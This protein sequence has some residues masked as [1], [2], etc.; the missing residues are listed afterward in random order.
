MC[1]E[2]NNLET[3]D[4]L[5]G[6]LSKKKIFKKENKVTKERNLVNEW[7]SKDIKNIRVEDFITN[8]SIETPN[9]VNFSK[10]KIL[11]HF[12][13]EKMLK[14]IKNQT[15]KRIFKKNKNFEYV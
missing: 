4:C 14:Y 6:L 2:E 9:F 5:D 12:L 7:I 10:L 1:Y 13:P 15:N 11:T 3:S 8:D